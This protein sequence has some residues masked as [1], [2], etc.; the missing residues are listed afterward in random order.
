MLRSILAKSVTSAISAGIAPEVGGIKG[1]AIAASIITG[2]IG[3][4]AA[5]SVIHWFGI[6]HPAAVGLAIGTSSH[7]AGTTKAIEIGEVEG[8]MSSIAIVVSGL[9]TVVLVPILIKLFL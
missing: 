3:A 9:M 7:T 4:V 1:I 5:R 8:A 6:K 2:V